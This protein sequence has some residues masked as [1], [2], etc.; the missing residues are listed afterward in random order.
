[1]KRATHD[2]NCQLCSSRQKLPGGVMAKHG[3]NVHFHYFQG[4]CQGSG[5]LPYERSCDLIKERIPGVKQMIVD[6]AKRAY[7]TERQTDNV[8][9]HEYIRA[10]EY[11]GRNYYQWRELHVSEMVELGFWSKWKG[12]D[13]HIKD[14]HT[15]GL[16]N[17]QTEDVTL[18][19]IKYLNH[20]R[21]AAYLAAK[22]E[23]EQYLNWLLEREAKWILTPL[24]PTKG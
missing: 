15:Y 11:G 13:G 21:A 16:P 12:V 8:W 23:M 22:R 10:A 2:G 4:V 1:M 17:D 14:T 6:L 20:R 3:Y 18:R 9:V 5:H 19:A 7:D 24:S